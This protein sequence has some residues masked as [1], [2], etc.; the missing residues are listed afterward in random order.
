MVVQRQV[1]D[2]KLTAACLRNKRHLSERD[3]NASS[4]KCGSASRWRMRKIVGG[5][6]RIA[7]GR[8]RIASERMKPEHDKKRRLKNCGRSDSEKEKE[9]S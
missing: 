3:M 5:R 9:R 7:N 4:L 8:K 2:P 6:R 1:V